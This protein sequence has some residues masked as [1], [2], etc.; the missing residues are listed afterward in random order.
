MPV[1]LERRKSTRV[2]FETSMGL[3][4]L[5]GGSQEIYCE[6]TRDISLKSVYCYSNRKLAPGTPCDI[7]LYVK[8]NNSRL[9]LFIKGQIVR[10]DDEG[11]GI[12][13]EEMDFESFVCLK[14]LLRYNLKGPKE[15]DLEFTCED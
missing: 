3:W 1:D 13:F 10:T 2:P 12:R 15:I 5:K 11:M 14:R 4:P 8:E 9:V 6:R 7:E